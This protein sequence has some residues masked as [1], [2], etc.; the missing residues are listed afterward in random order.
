M[1][2]FRTVGVMP[3]KKRIV[4]L[5]DRD[6]L[7]LKAL[8]KGRV[9]RT[10]DLTGTILPSLPVARRRMK[11][12][13]DAAFATGVVVGLHLD[14]RWVLGKEGR[15]LLGETSSANLVKLASQAGEHHFT[16]ARAW[17]T[18]AKECFASKE[19]GLGRFLF[20]WEYECAGHLPTLLPYRPDAVV[21]VHRGATSIPCLL[22][23]DLGSESPS[24]VATHKVQVFERMAAT[25]QGV[26]GVVPQ[27]LLVLVP[28]ER[29]LQALVRAVPR[30]TARV[31]VKVFDH[32]SST[33]G[34]GSGW[35][36][37]GQ[38]PPA[39]TFGLFEIAERT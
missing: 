6:R 39:A 35:T 1:V 27:I 13:H 3:R 18:L 21:V 7:V 34:L 10:S 4:V 38:R 32:T 20:Q 30:T 8:A 12:L 31:A 15:E 17:L 5:S 19:V 26:A 33:F 29:R 37:L 23:V 14:S 9:L 2:G 25:G 36:Q 11:R 22:E 28:T 16:T 24:Y